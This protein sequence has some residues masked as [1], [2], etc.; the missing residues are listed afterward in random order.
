[1]KYDCT[2]TVL[3]ETLYQVLSGEIPLE[4]TVLESCI[5]R[6]YRE[7]GMMTFNKGLV[8]RLADGSEF[9]LTIVQSR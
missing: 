3:E 9:Q 2:E 5:V 7:T 6:R 8:L 1:M 4:D